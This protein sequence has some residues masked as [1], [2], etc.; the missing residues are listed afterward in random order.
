MRENVS[1]TMVFKAN[2]V[3]CVVLILCVAKAFPFSVN[4]SSVFHTPS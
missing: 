1:M 4:I 3:K 2:D